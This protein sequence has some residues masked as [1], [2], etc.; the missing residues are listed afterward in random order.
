MSL[1]NHPPYNIPP[2]EESQQLKLPESLRRLLI[3]DENKVVKR[4]KAFRHTDRSLGKFFKRIKKHPVFEDT[5][6]II[7]AD[8]TFSDGIGF[9][10]QFGWKLDQNFLLIYNPQ[11]MKKKYVGKAYNHYTTHLDIVPTLATLLANEPIKLHTWGKNLFD[12][13]LGKKY[14]INHYFSCQKEYCLKKNTLY[15]LDESNNFIKTENSS[16]TLRLIKNI[17]EMNDAYYKSA[18]QYLYSY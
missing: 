3:K 6:F 1:T 13:S 16:K 11:I 14:G 15:L 10:D 7:T 9:P 5:L 2:D 12:F 4:F 8:H 17:R 18:M